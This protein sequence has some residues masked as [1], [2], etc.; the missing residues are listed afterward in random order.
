MSRTSLLF[1]KLQI[2]I[3]GVKVY[4]LSLNRHKEESEWI[5]EHQHSYSQILL[6]MTG[7]GT[8]K[9]EGRLFKV[10]AGTLICIPA[11]KN[12]EF[13]RIGRRRPMCLIIDFD[14]R[15]FREIKVVHLSRAEILSLHHDLSIISSFRG[16][17]ISESKLALASAILKIL[18]YLLRAAEWLPRKNSQ[19]TSPI[20]KKL[21]RILSNPETAT[22]PIQTLA[23]MM[24]YQKDYLNRMVKRISG[25]TLGQFRAQRRLEEAK[26]LLFSKP[27][28]RNVSDELAFSDQNYFARWFHQQTGLTP[29]Q[30][31]QK[32]L[33]KKS[34]KE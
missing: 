34:S 1:Q 17:S 33:Q 31:K 19:V 9:V 4:R 16:S 7:N 23:S 13:H 15:K 28:I 3:Q 25:L 18:D 2:A 5:D 12:H 27:L 30:W 24:G 14:I 32:T 20:I 26:K 6:Y 22:Q 10:S 21:E 11:G 8:Q 29:Q